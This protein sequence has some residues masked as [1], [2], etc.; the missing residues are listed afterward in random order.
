MYSQPKM[1]CIENIMSIFLSF[2]FFYFNYSF[3]RGFQRPR[4]ANYVEDTVP[5]YSLD[6]F[7]TFFRL[8]RTTFERVLTILSECQE[9]QI[10]TSSGG[11]PP[12]PVHQDLLMHLW[13]MGSQECV[14]SIADRFDVSE[15]TFVSQKNQSHAPLVSIIAKTS[16]AAV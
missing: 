13:Y 1:Y 5:L 9:L 15:S 14:R 7:K 16:T 11:R 4:V 8:S 12:I 2:N 3:R 6:T 10:N